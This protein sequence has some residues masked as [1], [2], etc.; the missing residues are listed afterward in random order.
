M[1]R[2]N[3]IRKAFGQRLCALRKGEF[4]TRK[5]LGEATKIGWRSIQSYECGWSWPDDL[6]V[7]HRLGKV[8]GTNLWGVISEVCE[9]VC[10]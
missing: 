9:E 1:T 6:S 8:L 5:K 4:L 10:E 7:I 2:N 3:R